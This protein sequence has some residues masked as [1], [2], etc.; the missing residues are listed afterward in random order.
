MKITES[1]ECEVR[2]PILLRVVGDPAP[3]GSSRAMLVAGCAVNVPSGSPQNARKLGGW[4]TAVT[5]AWEARSLCATNGEMPFRVGPVAI[6]ILFR[7]PCRKGDLDTGGAP[8]RAAPLLVVVKPD[9]DKLV[10]STLDALTHAGAWGDDSQAAIFLVGK[11]YTPPGMPIGATLILGGM[12][13]L[14]PEK[15]IGAVMT[16]W[17]SELGYQFS[18]IRRSKLDGAALAAE[19]RGGTRR[20]ARHAELTDSGKEPLLPI[21]GEALLDEPGDFGTADP[22]LAA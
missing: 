20:R 8:K 18:L 17:M 21:V 9:A 12:D 10:R 6:G 11:L 14:M 4:K 3:K 13:P 19:S 5:D 1:V 16:T 7:L 22:D 2:P 15:G